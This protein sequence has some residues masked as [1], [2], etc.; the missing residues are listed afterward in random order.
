MREALASGTIIHT[1]FRP[2]STN[3]G[4]GYVCAYRKDSTS[5]SGKMLACSCNAADFDALML[6]GK[7]SSSL[8][9]LSPT[10]ML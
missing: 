3:P 6:E 5:P 1:R 2:F 8:S 9:P 4:G 10:E 7:T